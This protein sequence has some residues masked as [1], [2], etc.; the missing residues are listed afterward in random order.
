MSDKLQR[1]TQCGCPKNGKGHMVRLEITPEELVMLLKALDDET[2]L[3]P[4][5][6]Q[7]L[8]EYIKS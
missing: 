5:T 8:A 4:Y 1:C 3:S 2:R 7:Q 6:R